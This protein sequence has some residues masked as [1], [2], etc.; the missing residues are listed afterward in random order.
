MANEKQ[1]NIFGETIGPCCTNP[2]TGFYRDGFCHTG[3]ND[4][5]MHT[6]CVQITLQFLEFS[7]EKGNDLMTPKPEFNFPGL[8]EGDHWCL[9]AARWLE[10]Y[11]AGKAP[12]V[13]LE[14][15]NIETLAIIPRSIL[16]QFKV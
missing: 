6:V 14:S 11:K 15:T 5:G 1:Q 4:R 3:V 13:K 16:E 2:L 8:K 7:K 10:A 9:C 12:K